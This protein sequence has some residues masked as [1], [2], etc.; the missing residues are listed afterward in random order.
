MADRFDRLQQI[1]EHVGHLARSAATLAEDTRLAINLTCAP[2]RAGEHTCFTAT[3]SL[4]S[5]FVDRS[6][7]IRVSQPCIATSSLDA[8]NCNLAKCNHTI[9]FHYSPITSSL[10]APRAVAKPK[11]RPP[12][13]SPSVGT[14]VAAE[15][16]RAF[17]DLP[18]AAPELTEDEGSLTSGSA[19]VPDAIA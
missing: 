11:P 16:N 14:R 3:S 5:D 6:G 10:E 1:A 17:A 2:T 19:C 13:F 7:P 8:P 18:D 9:L 15:A 4:H 12:A